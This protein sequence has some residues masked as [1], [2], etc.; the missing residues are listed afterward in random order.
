MADAFAVGDQ[1]SGLRRLF[2]R[3]AAPIIAVASIER[4]SARLSDR[5]RLMMQFADDFVAAGRTLTLLDEHPAASGIAQAYGVASHKDLKHALHGDYPLD[6]VMLRP[7]AG[8][9]LIPAPRAANMEFT[10]GDEAALAG[11]LALLRN[12][13]DCVLID[14]LQLAERTLSPIAASADRLL[15]VV[16]AGA[17][18]LTRAYGLIKR[19]V[20]EKCALPVSVVVVR[21]A[22]MGQA[23]AVYDKL[24]RVALDHLGIALHYQGA[25]LTPGARRLSLLPVA[26]IAPCR[27]GCSDGSGA[28]PGLWETADSML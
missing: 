9:T 15:V 1:A 3:H 28:A 24:R 22:D 2:V 13:S 6:E 12:V 7:V 14:S 17:N 8:L 19:A 25:A 26:A 5:A 11:N 4:G 27:S 18:D 21:A 23:R 16:P 20:M 10:L